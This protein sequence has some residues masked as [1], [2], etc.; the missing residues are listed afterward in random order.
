MLEK[1]SHLTIQ[2]AVIEIAE[3]EKRLRPWNDLC[4][5]GI[6]VVISGLIICFKIISRPLEDQILDPKVVCSSYDLFDS[7]NVEDVDL[8]SVISQLNSTVIS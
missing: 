6:S 1:W 5:I 2:P 3:H 8:K 4:P 7:I